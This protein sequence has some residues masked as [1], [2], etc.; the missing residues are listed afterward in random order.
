MQQITNALQ[1]LLEMV[2]KRG[3]ILEHGNYQ[4][5]SKEKRIAIAHAGPLRWP[6]S[7]AHFAGLQQQKKRRLDEPNPAGIKIN[8]S[9]RKT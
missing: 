2:R 5:E 4:D 6:V 1:R 3:R 7:R 9:L 8:Q